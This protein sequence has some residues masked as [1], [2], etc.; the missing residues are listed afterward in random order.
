MRGEAYENKLFSRS[1]IGDQAYVWER[2]LPYADLHLGQHVR[3]RL[4]LQPDR[5][6][7]SEVGPPL[8]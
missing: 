7:P 5:G 1:K 6:G 2:V 8:R 4:T 3:V